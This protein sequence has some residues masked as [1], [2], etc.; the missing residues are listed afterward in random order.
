MFR[1][2]NFAILAMAIGGVLLVAG[3][4]GK[5]TV[6]TKKSDDNKAVTS[7]VAVPAKSGENKNTETPIAK[8]AT[9]VAKPAAQVVKPTVVS[10][11]K[12]YTAYGALSDA[13]IESIKA[14]TKES[15]NKITNSLTLNVA[16]DNNVTGNGNMVLDFVKGKD[17][18]MTFVYSGKLQDNKINGN[19]AIVAKDYK[20]DTKEV[21]FQQSFTM[22]WYAEKSGSKING[23]IYN[24]TSK[25]IMFAF[26][27]TVN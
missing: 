18:S 1:R 12:A 21:S 20:A 11:N 26:T 17:S 3:C 2:I 13:S 25:Q 10:K 14:T 4:G 15:L 9:Q 6:N 19:V 7:T 22:A 5:P 8:P 16:A 27:A 24:A 23:Q